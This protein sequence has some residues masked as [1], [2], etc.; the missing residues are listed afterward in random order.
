MQSITLEL[1]GIPRE[2]EHSL[3]L[4]GDHSLIGKRDTHISNFKARESLICVSAV[5]W[6]ERGIMVVCKDVEI[7]LFLYG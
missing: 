1:E 5:L 2:R 6:K 3:Y 7:V 4:L